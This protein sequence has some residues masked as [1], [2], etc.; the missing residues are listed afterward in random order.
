MLK[1]YASIK[2]IHI[3][4]DQLKKK[5]NLTML[6]DISEPDLQRLMKSLYGV[7]HP[8]LPPMNLGL[9][10]QTLPSQNNNCEIFYSHNF[11]L[12][13]NFLKF[14]CYNNLEEKL[15]LQRLTV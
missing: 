4:L 14:H 12:I 5:S 2:H 8:H 3:Q 7:S 9:P 6:S 15:V 11:S 1:P 10:L 13:T